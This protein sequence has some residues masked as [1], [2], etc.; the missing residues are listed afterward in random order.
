MSL[1]QCNKCGLARPADEFPLEKNRKGVAVMRKQCRE[2]RNAYHKRYREA[3]PEYFKEAHEKNRDHRIETMVLTNLRRRHERYT[4]LQQCKS[5]PCCDCGKQYPPVAMDFDHRDPASKLMDVSMLAKRGAP[6]STL[7]AE[8]AKC[9]VV[10]RNC[11]ALRTYKGRDTYRKNPK[12]SKK[13]YRSHRFHTNY[14]KIA[15]IK[16]GT[17]CLDCGGYFKACQMEY[18]HVQPKSFNISQG[19]S[20]PW[21]ELQAELNKC[22][23]VC[24]NCH[25]VRTLNKMPT[26]GACQRGTPTPRTRRSYIK[27]PSL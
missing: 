27:G 20:K 5:V 6:W 25:R 23:L 13:T 1:V 22:E 26:S 2:C 4:F 14:K 19:V 15:E 8:I 12:V 18:D 11:H 16:E 7:V 21:D 24:A 10:C 9:D 17:P 3:N